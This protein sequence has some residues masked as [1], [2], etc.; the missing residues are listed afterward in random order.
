MFECAFV[1]LFVSLRPGVSPSQFRK[2]D[3]RVSVPLL[4][5]LRVGEMRAAAG[6]TDLR[7]YSRMK[8]L[9]DFEFVF[10]VVST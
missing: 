9:I 1:S 6:H 2:I 4:A 7:M 8:N 10:D 3:E 5:S